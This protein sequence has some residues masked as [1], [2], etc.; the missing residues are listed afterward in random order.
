MEWSDGAS[1][2]VD[3]KSTGISSGEKFLKADLDGTC[4]W[5]TPLY[6]TPTVV[7]VA[8]ESS[9]TDCNVWFSTTATG[10]IAPKT[11]TN[12]TFNSSNGRLTATSFAGDGSALTGI[13]G[14]NITGLL[15][16]TSL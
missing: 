3:V 14:M 5:Q 6:P 8:D 12:L 1:E 10:N 13:E 9:D 11:G 2:G 15:K 7:T 4:S 16:L